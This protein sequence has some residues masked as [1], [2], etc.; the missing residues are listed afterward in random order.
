MGKRIK[1]IRWLAIWCPRFTFDLG[2]V[3]IPVGLDV[4]KPRVLQEFKRLAHGVRSSNVSV[5][6]AKTFYVPNFHF[7]G[8]I[9]SYFWA[10]NGSE[11]NIMGIK[12]PNEM[13]LYDS[14]RAY[15]GE[16]IEIQLPGSLTVHNIDWISI[17][18]I[19]YRQNFG[20]V[21]I[22]KDLLDV[23]PALGQTKL[24]PPWWYKPTTTTTSTTSSPKVKNCRTLLPKRMQIKWEIGSTYIEIELLGRILDDQFML[25]GFSKSSNVEENGA[26]IV[27]AYFD[28]QLN[29]FVVEDYFISQFSECDGKHG[30][31]QDSYYGGKND[32]MLL[33]GDRKNS[34]TIIKFKRLLQTN[35]PFADEDFMINSH[36][37]V[38]GFIGMLD[39]T[40]K[41]KFSTSFVEAIQRAIKINFSQAYDDDCRV[42]LYT[43]TEEI[44][45]W[46]DNILQD[47]DTFYVRV[48]PN[49]DKRNKIL[50]GRWSLEVV[51]YINGLMAPEIVVERGKT[52]TFVIET[53]FD[54]E[55][56][57]RYYPFY[58]T[59]SPEG[60]IKYKLPDEL[61]NHVFY[62]GIE[63]SPEGYLIPTGVG[64]FCIYTVDF[65]IQLQDLS[66]NE[67]KSS[68]KEDCE[69]GQPG[70]LNW[71]VP[72]DAPDLL[73]YQCFSEKNMGWQITV[74]NQ[75]FLTD[76]AYKNISNQNL[77]IMILSILLFCPNI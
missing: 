18:S 20:H 16:D 6:D 70:I 4:P 46:P 58:I 55:V 57:K 10:G 61:K 8:E 36:M 49:L 17:W 68:L 59:N 12:V 28:V 25:L 47:V 21:L 44:P 38:F 75:T 71:T 15:Q 74:I 40:Q 19:S 45:I 3:F 29:N 30:L 48:G 73:Y 69:E 24:T 53:G 54:E 35:E 72:L 60:N 9:E 62:L 64:Q 31:C 1:D 26:D 51:Y 76:F 27:I 37:T 65:D 77:F 34:T 2:E 14:L 22:P 56:S 13:G 67:L 32:I 5:L 63:T 50:Y 41:P 42:N 23:P 11:P 33:T 43:I 66:K 52:Y 39:S 7:D